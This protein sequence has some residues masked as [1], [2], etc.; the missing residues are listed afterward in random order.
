MVA[1]TYVKQGYMHVDRHF[2]TNKQNVTYHT[3]VIGAHSETKTIRSL[4]S[5]PTQ[6]P[7][8][9]HKLVSDRIMNI[10]KGNDPNTT[11]GLQIFPLSLFKLLLMRSLLAAFLFRD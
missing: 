11:T 5:F 8:S 10:I 6:I 7:V 2:T 3:S 9:L 4:C 1:S